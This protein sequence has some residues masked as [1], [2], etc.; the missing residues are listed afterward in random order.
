MDLNHLDKYPVFVLNRR[1]EEF[2]EE[3]QLVIIDGTPVTSTYRVVAM[4]AAGVKTMDVIAQ[5]YRLGP[6]RSMEL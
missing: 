5:R 3:D 1:K 2:F 4:P 6:L